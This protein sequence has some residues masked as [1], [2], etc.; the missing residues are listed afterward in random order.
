M[1]AFDLFCMCYVKQL[2]TFHACDVRE[3]HDK[4]LTI[5]GLAWHPHLPHLAY[6]DDH[7]YLGV[8][9]NISPLSSVSGVPSNQVGSAF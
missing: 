3:K 1:F 8:S 2:S 4:G 5:T 7:G 6:C 9:N